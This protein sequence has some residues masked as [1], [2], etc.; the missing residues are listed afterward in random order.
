MPCIS[1]YASNRSNV[2]VKTK[3]RAGKFYALPIVEN[4]ASILP[5]KNVKIDIN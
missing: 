4:K 3:E 2:K 5:R 1:Q